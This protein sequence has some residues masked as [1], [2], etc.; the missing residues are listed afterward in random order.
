MSREMVCLSCYSG[1]LIRI[2]QEPYVTQ[3]IHPAIR[4]V[5]LTA[6]CCSS[7]KRNPASALHIS[8]LPTSAAEI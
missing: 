3:H 2:L 5:P 1:M 4:Q 6:P 8:V 7:L